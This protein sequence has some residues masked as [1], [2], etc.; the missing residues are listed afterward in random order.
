MENTVQHNYRYIQVQPISGA[1]G[2]QIEGVNLANPLSCGIATEIRQ[3]FLDHLAIFF[4]NQK[5]TPLQQLVFAQQ[6][7]QPIEYPQLMGLLECPLV[8]AV[9]KLEHEQ[10]NFGGVWHSDT[11]YLERPPM[12]SML[13]AVEIPPYGGDTLFANQ[14]LAY[15]GLSNGLKQT[16]D[17]LTGVNVSTKPEVSMTR[18]NRL[19]ESGVELKA[20]VAE[21]PVVRT[22]P[23]TGRKALYVNNAHTSHFKGWTEQESQPLLDYLFKHQI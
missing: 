9:T 16:L 22:H 1:L 20:L 7:G 4:P 10:A 21:H 3:S 5:L 2:A 8:T 15:D 17:G 6:F 12:A 13:Y 19:R 14:Y 23:E 18:E 11:T